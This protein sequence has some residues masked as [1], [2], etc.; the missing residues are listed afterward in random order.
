MHSFSKSVFRLYITKTCLYNFDPLKPHFYIVKLGFTGVYIV[1]HIS[2]QNIDFIEK[3]GLD[4]SCK[5][6]RLEIICMEYQN[7]L[8]FFFLFL[9]FC[10]FFFFFFWKNT[11]T[12]SNCRLLKICTRMLSVKSNFCETNQLFNSIFTHNLFPPPPAIMLKVSTEMDL[13]KGGSNEYPQSMF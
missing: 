9:F 12:F 6:L 8:F 1:F 7:L 11:K 10:L 3:T 5:F 2:A 4:I 13:F